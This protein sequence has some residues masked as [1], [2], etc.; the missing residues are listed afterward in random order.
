MRARVEVQPVPVPEYLVPV[1]RGMEGGKR[2]VTLE[3]LGAGVC[4]KRACGGPLGLSKLRYLTN[5][6]SVGG[7]AVARIESCDTAAA[8]MA[9]MGIRPV[10][11]QKVVNFIS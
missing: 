8:P 3:I 9:R 7:V 6:V 2:S 4:T 10:I 5:S 1:G 11:C